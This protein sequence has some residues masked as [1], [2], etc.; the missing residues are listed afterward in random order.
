MTEQMKTIILKTIYQQTVALMLLALFL[1]PQSATCMLMGVGSTTVSSSLFLLVGLYSNKSNILHIAIGTLLK[2]LSFSILFTFSL[3]SAPQGWIHILSGAILG[4]LLYLIS[5][6][7]T[8]ES[9][10]H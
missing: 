10:G 3:L 6:Y 4:Q 7:L 8:Q 5:C 2:Y 9:Y 1:L